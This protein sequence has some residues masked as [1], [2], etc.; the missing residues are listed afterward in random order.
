MYDTSALASQTLGIAGMGIGLS[1][2]ASTARHVQDT[3]QSPRQTRPTRHYKPLRV[4]QM[5]LTTPKFKW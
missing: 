4:K 1:I 5:K 2:I 3:M